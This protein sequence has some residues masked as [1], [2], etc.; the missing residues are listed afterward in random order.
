MSTSKQ[1]VFDSDGHLVESLQDMSPF[2]PPIVRSVAVDKASMGS[3]LPLSISSLFGTL[4]G[5]HFMP[6]KSEFKQMPT[7][8]NASSHRMGSADDWIAFL[9]NSCTE[10]TVLYPTEA[11]GSGLLRD[12]SYSVA[13]TRAYNDYVHECYQRKD[14]RLH[15]MAILPMQSPQDAAKELRRAVRELGLPGAMLQATGLPLHLSHEYYWPVY[16]EAEK[17]GCVLAIHGGS[18]RFIG[19]DSFEKIGPSHV[20]H[21]PIPLMYALIGLVYDSVMDRCP[22]VRWAFLEG[23]AAWL[24]LLLDRTARDTEVGLPYMDVPKKPFADYLTSGKVLIGC[25]GVDPSLPYLAS[26]LGIEPFSYSTDYPHEV[27]FVHAMHEVE[28][29]LESKELTADQKAAVLDK[30][31]RRFYTGK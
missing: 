9:D 21:H 11:L 3:I 26:R 8:K 18:N 30:N 12:V 25:E 13:I 29:T 22:S 20:L 24:A 6:I 4:D 27:D 15:A 2:L 17:L 14:K 5:L 16:D 10:A 23:G 1:T 7:R 31:A 28:E 19:M